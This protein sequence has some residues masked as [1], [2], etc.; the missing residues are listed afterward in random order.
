MYINLGES[1]EP[2]IGKHVFV[3]LRHSKAFN[4]PWCMRYCQAIA[5]KIA[6]CFNEDMRGDAW[7]LNSES[8]I[9]IAICQLVLQYQGSL[10]K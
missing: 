10:L 8:M 4:V 9:A 6:M 1:S 7:W 2:C 5:A 3:R